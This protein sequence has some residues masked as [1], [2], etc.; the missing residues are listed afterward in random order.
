MAASTLSFLSTGA[1][2]DCDFGVSGALTG[3]EAFI[4]S[5]ALAGSWAF[6]GCEIGSGAFL[7]SGALVIS[8]AFF[9]SGALTSFTGAL[10]GS[11]A[12]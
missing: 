6:D 5:G 11:G 10:I 9:T 3:E 4:G 8:G 12:F 7:S 1:Y 2:I